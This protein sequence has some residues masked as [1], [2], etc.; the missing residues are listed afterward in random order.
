MRAGEPDRHVVGDLDD[1]LRDHPL[2]G[3]EPFDDL[4][5]AGEPGAGA[6]RYPLGPAPVVDDVDEAALALADHGQLGHGQSETRLVLDDDVHHHS[7]AEQPVGIGQSRADGDGAGVGI[8]DRVDGVDRASERPVGISGGAGL[9]R[10]AGADRSEHRLGNGEID[11]DRAD[12]ADRRDLGALVGDRADRDVAKRDPAG[13][14]R[15]DDSLADLGIGLGGLG[16][17]G[18]G[19]GDLGVERGLGGEAALLELRDSGELLLGLA[20]AGLGLVQLGVLL[21]LLEHGDDLAGADEAAVVEIQADDPLRHR[22]R[23][24]HLLVGAGGADRLHPVGEA[25]AGRGLRLDQ[26]RG[27]VL[28]LLGLGTATGGQGERKDRE[29]EK[30]SDHGMI[31]QCANFRLCRYGLCIK[32]SHPS[33]S[34]G[35]GAVASGSPPSG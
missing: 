27:P 11:L 13:E 10:K 4:D 32:T 28:A 31:G 18:G 17:G 5:P 3:P 25:K 12:V 9:D 30:S 29:E 2:A 22:R 1:A 16:A 26:R 7:G 8:D 21:G 19:G 20:G 6:D 24:R 23:D 15:P 35:L 34:G 14:R 33:T